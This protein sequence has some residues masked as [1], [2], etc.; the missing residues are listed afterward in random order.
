MSHRKCRLTKHQSGRQISCCIVCLCDILSGHLV[1]RAGQASVRCR[2]GLHE[3]LHPAAAVA[4]GEKIGFSNTVLSDILV[5]V[6]AFGYSRNNY[7][8]PVHFCL[9]RQHDYIMTVQRALRYHEIWLP[10]YMIPIL[11]NCLI[12]SRPIIPPRV[13]QLNVA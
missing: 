8:L 9:Q 7:L 1:G 2:G 6:T 4:L 12:K 10:A 3:V 11:S 5:T 13:V